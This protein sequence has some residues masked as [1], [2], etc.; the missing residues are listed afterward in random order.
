MRLSNHRYGLLTALGIQEEKGI[1]Q[2]MYAR[3]KNVFGRDV[4]AVSTYVTR[5]KES[6]A[7]F[8]TELGRYT[9]KK[10]FIVSSNGKIDPILRFFDLNTDYL[11]YKK[12]GR[13]IEDLKEFEGREDIATPFLNQFFNK[14]DRK[15]V[16]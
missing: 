2:R 6:M 12:E 16:V 10:N 7:A 14:E 15:S 8:L 11:A 1:A 4:R 13:W 9:S 3:E 5:T